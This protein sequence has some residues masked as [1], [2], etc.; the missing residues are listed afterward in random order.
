M[1]E[2][3]NIRGGRGS[4]GEG[5]GVVVYEWSNNKFWETVVEFLQAVTVTL[6]LS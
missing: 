1:V 4:G 6:F 3:D 5:W 2:Y